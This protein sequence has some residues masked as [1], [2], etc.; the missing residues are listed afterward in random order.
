MKFNPAPTDEEV[1]YDLATAMTLGMFI[2]MLLDSCNASA[3]ILR[4]TKG[5]NSIR[6]M[7]VELIP[8]GAVTS[9]IERRADVRVHETLAA[10]MQGGVV[11]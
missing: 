8:N 9:E 7:E 3:V 2:G 1:Q 6:H 4:V 10:L 11:K 5:E